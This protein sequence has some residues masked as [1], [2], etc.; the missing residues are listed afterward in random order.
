[1]NF[2][3]FRKDKKDIK[4]IVKKQYELNEL[5]LSRTNNLIMENRQLKRK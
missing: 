1:M 4:D 3:V 5:V 2:N